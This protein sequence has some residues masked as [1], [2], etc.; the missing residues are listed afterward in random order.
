[1]KMT[2][3]IKDNPPHYGILKDDSNT[4]WENASV[5]EYEHCPVSGKP[6]S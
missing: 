5:N 1:M 2:S 3:F 4:T 6:G